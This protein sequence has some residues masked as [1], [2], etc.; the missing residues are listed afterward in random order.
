MRQPEVEAQNA[1]LAAKRLIRLALKAALAT[2]HEGTGYPYASL[3]TVACEPCGAPLLLIS[4][5]AQHTK[6]LQADARASILFDGTDGLGDPLQGGRVSVSGRVAPTEDPAARARFLARHPEAE[7]YADFAD[8]AFYRMEVEGAHY[9][10]GFGKIHDLG[11]ADL[12]VAVDGATPLIE[13]E[14]GI[15]AHMNDDHADAIELYATRLLGGTGGAWRMTGCDP[16][17]CDLVLGERTLR[18]D[19]PDRVTSPEEVRKCLVA[20]VQKARNGGAPA[21]RPDLT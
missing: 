14:P 10:G 15:V 1:A 6:N 3:I 11:A 9:I 12:L 4:K 17:G 2:F 20:L 8:F 19:F 5:L 21:G 13:A 18:L 16:E 7:G